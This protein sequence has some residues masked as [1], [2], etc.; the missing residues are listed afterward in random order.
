[1]Y[2]LVLLHWHSVRCQQS[3]LWVW[4]A[5]PFL[6][7]RKSHFVLAIK[8]F[9]IP[10]PCFLKVYCFWARATKD[11]FHC[12]LGRVQLIQLAFQAQ[13]KPP[14]DTALS[15]IPSTVMQYVQA[16]WEEKAAL[17]WESSAF[18]C[19]ST[20]CSELMMMNTSTRQ[21]IACDVAACRYAFGRLQSSLWG[22][23]TSGARRFTSFQL[24][25]V[26][27][28]RQTFQTKSTSVSVSPIKRRTL[29]DGMCLWWGVFL[30]W[31]LLKTEQK[32]KAI[33]FAERFK[34]FNKCGMYSTW[35]RF[36]T[37]WSFY[38]LSHYNDKSWK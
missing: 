37:P 1:M 32:K 6:I 31:S 24:H 23:G 3:Q 26:I 29:E 38:V 2:E 22:P 19:F 20:R 9:A 25:I 27:S 15:H 28:S 30:I 10:P 5:T 35:S 7:M 33:H 8:L 14:A 16:L 36:H 12:L 18:G 13:H 21:I 4:C 34:M 17:R 11:H